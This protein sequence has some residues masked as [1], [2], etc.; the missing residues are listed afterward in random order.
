VTANVWSFKEIAVNS[1]VEF[2]SMLAAVV[3]GIVFLVMGV[4]FVTM[5]YNLGKHPGEPQ[6]G[7]IAHLS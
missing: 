1:N 3:V 5:P 7:A 6:H 2:R 4:A